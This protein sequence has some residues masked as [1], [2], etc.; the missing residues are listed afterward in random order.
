MAGDEARGDFLVLSGV[1]KSY[2][3][4]GGT[5]PLCILR[6][7][8]LRVQRGES[9]SIVG[10]SGS[11]KTTL[12]NIIGTLDRPDAGHVLLEGQDLARLDEAALALTRNRSIGFIFQSHYLLPHLTVLENVLVPTLA[13]G[14]SDSRARAPERARR[15]LRRVG[16][17]SRLDHR[18]SQ[19][20]GGERQRAAV[21]RA[22]INEP[23]L[24]LADEPT[25]ALDQ[26]SAQELGTLLR[27]LNREEGVT[28]I[29]VTHSPNLA[30]EMGRRF[31]LREGTLI[32]TE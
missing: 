27:D 11:G 2:V 7:V 30:R 1:G 22:L 10:P 19:L 31:E 5:T 15:L 28:L 17:E 21:V 20:S 23:M 32:E 25:G 16:L 6:D 29:A 24:L 3:S 4:A 18:P 14:H 13:S 26:H 12:L 8:N 9:L